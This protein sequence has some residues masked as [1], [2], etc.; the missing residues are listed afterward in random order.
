MTAF[1][2]ATSASVGA[3][4]RPT[5]WRGRSLTCSHRLERAMPIT[6]DTAFTANRPEAATRIA[7][8][9]FRPARDLQGLFQ[10][11][12]FQGLLAEQ[13]LQLTDLV[14]ERAVI[15]GRHDLLLGSGCGQPTL[16]GE[17]PP[18][19]ELVWGNPVL[20]RHQAHRHA[21]REGRLHKAHLLGS[22]PAPPSLNRGD[23][24]N[25][26]RDVGHRH[27]CKPHTC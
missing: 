4:G 21:R 23:D 17:P 8:A 5:R 1:I 15:R 18:S 3:G 7:T 6:S 11:F 26:V 20:A 13:P 24:L 19:E 10:D 2:S 16:G 22:G 9:P 14:L 25:A 12:G 27:G